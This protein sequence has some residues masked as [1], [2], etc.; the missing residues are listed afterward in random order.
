VRAPCPHRR[1]IKNLPPLGIDSPNAFCK[2]AMCMPERHD[3]VGLKMKRAFGAAALASRLPQTRQPLPSTP[4]A[5]PMRSIPRCR[6]AKRCTPTSAAAIRVREPELSTRHRASPRAAI[7]P[8]HMSPPPIRPPAARQASFLPRPL[9]KPRLS[10][11]RPM[12]RMWLSTSGRWMRRTFLSSTPHPGI[13]RIRALS[14]QAFPA[15]ASPA[16]ARRR[17][18]A[19]RQ[20]SASPSLTAPR[21]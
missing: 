21:T 6:Q 2:L 18:Q 4:S 15:R 1:N 12:L 13:S 11:L 16:T 10:P 8:A 5:G 20:T 3:E 14:L 7:R 19:R 9:E 17:S